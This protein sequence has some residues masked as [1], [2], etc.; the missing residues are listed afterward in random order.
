MIG[1]TVVVVD[2]CFFDEAAEVVVVVD[3]W[4]VVVVVDL[5]IVVVVEFDAVVVV[6][7]AGADARQVGTV[8]TFESSVTAPLRAKT[9]P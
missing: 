1:W 2:L 5:W 3:L 4:I 6:V 7:A 9:R 8:T